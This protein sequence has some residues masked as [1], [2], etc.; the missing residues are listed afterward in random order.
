MA[1]PFDI[2]QPSSVNLSTWEAA[3]AFANEWYTKEL[4]ADLGGT[5]GVAYRGLWDMADPRTR[6][7]MALELQIKELTQPSLG[8]R[9]ME[10]VLGFVGI[11]TGGGGGILDIFEP[12]VGVEDNEQIVGDTVAGGSAVVNNFLD[13][14]VNNTTD[15][16]DN[17]ADN[18]LDVMDGSTEQS[19]NAISALAS[20][21]LNE[22]GDNNSRATNAL[23]GLAS[24]IISSVDD[25]HK[26]ALDKVLDLFGFTNSTINDLLRG[27]VDLVEIL[28][29]RA[30]G[31]IGEAV[32][33]SS[34]TIAASFAD[35]GDSIVPLLTQAVES[36]A[37]T[38][39]K[40]NTALD[41][42]IEQSRSNAETAEQNLTAAIDAVVTASDSAIAESTGTLAATGQAQVEATGEAA[43]QVSES[44]ESGTGGVAKEI[45]EFA[46]V[47][48]T[49]TDQETLQQVRE[50]LASVAELTG[51]PTEFAPTIQAFI[52][53]VLGRFSVMGALG[54]AQ[55][56]LATFQSLIGPVLEVFGNCMSQAA[57][58]QVPT[59]LPSAAD[60]RDQLNRALIPETEA[61]NSLL[62]Q[63]YSLDRAGILLAQRRQIPDIGIVQAWWL[64]GFITTEQAAAFLRDLGYDAESIEHLIQM[65]FF[66]PPVGDLITMAVREVFTP[67]IAARF[68]QFEDFPTAFADFARLQGVSDE[69]ARNY[70]AA[71]WALPSA[72]QGFEMFQRKVISRDDLEKLLKALDV[73]PFWRDKLTQIAYRPI[74]RV[75]VRRLHALGVLP[76]E[77]LQARYE[78]FGF[79]PGDATLMAEF[80]VA[81]NA[82]GAGEDVSELAGVTKSQALRFFK[83][84]TLTKS[85][86][87]EILQAQ[88]LSEQ[89]I[90]ILITQTELEV[91]EQNREAQAKLI[92]EQAKA[93]AITFNQAEDRLGQV[94]LEPNELARALA[95]LERA[96][97]SNTKIPTRTEGERMLKQGIINSSQYLDLLERLGYSQTW[98][99]RFLELASE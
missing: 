61:V 68:G 31:A 80:T 3:E 78:A 52:L 82:R 16:F 73:M 56:T 58:R 14:F 92:I 7:I 27:N 22:I 44:I 76:T 46:E 43:G 1:N 64:R 28:T 59:A 36:N 4:F 83:N 98:S 35:I 90:D 13:G 20:V 2:P 25:Q 33:S 29:E 93:G 72:Q 69:W 55:L 40:I 15:I 47:F 67:E 49:G 74:P 57:A 88:G 38:S 32:D 95:T 63:G 23:E 81:Y 94:G 89:A 48:G 24:G 17:L 96:Q 30:L 12:I 77:D 54:Q 85:Q 21:I 19:Q 79:A 53:E 71:H 99:E 45:K 26:N 50:S 65:S 84:G 9:I 39:E 42:Q 5:I 41:E 75:D 37:E 10:D 87:V 8:S 66:I 62:N 70:W 91:E 60:L 86:T 34:S 18:I 97:A 11:A 51:C 6:W